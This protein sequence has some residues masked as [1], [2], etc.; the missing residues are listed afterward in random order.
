MTDNSKKV[1][2]LPIA[3]NAESTDRILILRTPSGNASV[4]TI[5]L[6]NLTASI[7]YANTTVAGLIKVGNNLSINATGF[8]GAV[9]PESIIAN[10]S[11]AGS[12]KVGNNLSINATGFLSV[13]VANTT[14]SG[15]VKV[16]NNLSVNAT[17]F[18]NVIIPESIIA[19]TTVTGTIKVGNNLSINATGFLNV[20]VAN[21]INIGAFSINTTPAVMN[22]NIDAIQVGNVLNTNVGFSWHAGNTQIAKLDRD[23]H[24]VLNKIRTFFTASNLEIKVSDQ[25]SNTHWAFQNTGI[26]HIPSGIGDIYKDGVSVLSSIPQN[27]TNT[28][29]TLAL[30]D[31]GKHILTQNN[32]TSQIITVPN[33]S[34]VAYSTGAEVTI[35]VQTTGTVAVA[36]GVGVT[37]YL[38]G[39]SDSKSTITLNSYSVAKLLKI[40]TDTWIVSGTGVS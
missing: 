35:V 39:N 13:N 23:G 27:F 34:S 22:F 15:V 4:R 6:D 24:L 26:L 18:L 10:T 21:S 29:F 19:N 32:G 20:D 8:L 12:V 31:A 9:V 36:N 3:A 40:G 25:S 5:T 11:V 17:G 1:S 37:M 16:G 2:Q 30:T 14:T 33:N 38:A 7:R 28:S